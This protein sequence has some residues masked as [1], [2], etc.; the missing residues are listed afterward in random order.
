MI[1]L[2]PVKTVENPEHRLVE[3][4]FLPALLEDNPL[5][6][7]RDPGYRERLYA[8]GERLAKALLE[9]DWSVFAG[10]FL[11][12]FAYHRHTIDP[13]D[14]PRNWVRFRGYDWGFADPA[15]MLWLAKEP[16]TARLFVYR[17]M[18]ESGL[19]DP[20][21]AE[22]INDMTETYERFAFTFADPSAWT[23][24][25][26]E[27]IAKSTYDVFL[28]HQILLSKADNKQERK[29]H[30]IHS[31]LGDIHDGEPG[32][33]IFKNCRNLIGELEGLMSDPDHQERPLRNQLD[34]AYDALCYSLSN[35][36]PPTVTG[37]RRRKS[38][39]KSPFVDMEGI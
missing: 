32:L 7:Q 23:R 22:R 1:D 11:S 36:I 26:T 15:C 2:P 34:H 37:R 9:G 31:A 27:I 21:Q 39:S 18:Y 3:S 17:E 4:V 28:K 6:E 30:R 12:E 29:S 14:I 13:F 35:Y 19:T 10:Q 16:S 24:R 33:K 8:Q 20:Q 38:N 5:L 25:T